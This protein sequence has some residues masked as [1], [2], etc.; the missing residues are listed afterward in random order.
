MKIGIISDIHEDVIRLKEALKILEKSGVNEVVCLGDMVG[1]C[2]PFYTYWNTR[3]ANEVIRIVQSECSEVVIGNHDLYAIRKIPSHEG[4]FVYPDN[5]YELDYIQKVKLAKNK[6]YI[7]DNELPHRLE[8]KY[9][10]YLWELPEYVVKHLGNYNVMLSHY[11]YPDI[12]G[13]STKE[14]KAAN[15]LE[16]HFSFM[17]KNNCLYG[18]SGNDHFE[19]ISYFS[20]N[21]EGVIYFGENGRLKEQEIWLHGP[22]VSQGTFNN[23]VMIFDSESRVIEAVPLNSKVHKVYGE[24]IQFN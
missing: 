14:I 4:Y 7:Y 3:D 12:T 16:E 1:F 24:Y 23:G 18:F 20:N 10:E 13:S 5:W 2:T 15:Q 11:A 9:M 8:K 6:V 22:T 17:K 21:D 19:G